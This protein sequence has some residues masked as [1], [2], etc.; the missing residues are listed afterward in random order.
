[1]KDREARKAYLQ[2]LFNQEEARQEASQGIEGCPV[3]ELYSL[4]SYLAQLIDSGELEFPLSEDVIYV[5]E[6]AA[7]AEELR[8]ELLVR[9]RET[10]QKATADRERR[11]MTTSFG[12]TLQASRYKLGLSGEEVARRVGITSSYLA[13]IEENRVSPIRIAI[14]NMVQL[15]LVLKLSRKAVFDIVRSQATISADLGY[16]GAP[17]TRLDKDVTPWE[18]AESLAISEEELTKRT[19][20]DIEK[21]L[22]NLS[23]SLEQAGI[24]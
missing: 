15:S 23:K 9:L 24:E 16:V 22:L 20:I 5:L 11:K 3:D 12:A 13:E 8:P 10:M 17:L 19:K 6:E 1:M 2:K 21:Y 7:Q 18:R 4:D 14:D